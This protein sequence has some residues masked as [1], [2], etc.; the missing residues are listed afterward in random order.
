MVV[1]AICLAVDVGRALRANSYSG[2]LARSA[3]RA[4][5]DTHDDGNTAAR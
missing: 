2:G 4:M 1:F 3:F 5:V